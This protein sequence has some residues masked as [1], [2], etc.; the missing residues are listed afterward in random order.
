MKKV[1]IIDVW[2]VGEV[3]ATKIDGVYTEEG[4]MTYD[5]LAIT[6]DGDLLAYDN[7]GNSWIMIWGDAN[8]LGFYID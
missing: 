3:A 8:A 7:G 2:G 4:G 5:E 1:E 6:V